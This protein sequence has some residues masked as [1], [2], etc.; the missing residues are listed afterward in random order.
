MKRY[1]T[2]KG[3]GSGLAKPDVIDGQDI[4]KQAMWETPTGFWVRY[5]DHA[6]VVAELHS[7][8]S[9]S[10]PAKHTE[11]SEAVETY[12]NPPKFPIGSRIRHTSSGLGTVVGL[13]RQAQWGHQM[14]VSVQYDD[15]TRG[16]DGLQHGD[17]E[18]N[19][20]L[21]AYPTAP[22]FTQQDLDAAY[23][24]GVE[25]AYTSLFTAQIKKATEA[26]ITQTEADSKVTKQLLNELYH[27]RA[28]LERIIANAVKLGKRIVEHQERKGGGPSKLSAEGQSLLNEFKGFIANNDGTDE[29]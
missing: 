3:K 21:V 14:C 15:K 26:A 24:K 8:F 18:S 23:N 6:E 17:F 13:P 4:G 19:M 29:S 10:N 16:V 1:H 9:G 27:N 5:S 2:V 28:R 22:C 12:L 25:T 20:K 11:R 7:R